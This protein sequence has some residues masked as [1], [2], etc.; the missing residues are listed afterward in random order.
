M[1]IILTEFE[2]CFA[3]DLL[4]ET[5]EDAA[6]LVRLGMDGT[7]EVR[8][9]ATHVNKDGGFTAHVVVG[10]HRKADSCVPRRR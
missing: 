1:K 8:S 5:K 9:L 10:K 7:Q 2:K 6:L 3:F 4:A